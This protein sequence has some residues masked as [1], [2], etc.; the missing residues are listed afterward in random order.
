MKTYPIPEGFKQA[1]YALHHSGPM[2]ETEIA[3]F[4]SKKARVR[5]ADEARCQPSPQLELPEAA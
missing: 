2:T 3:E 1:R 4:E 5:H